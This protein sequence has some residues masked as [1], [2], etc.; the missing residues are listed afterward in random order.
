MSHTG[1]II[2]IPGL[3]IERVARTQGIEVW[4]KP[5]HRPRCKHCYRDGL[6]IKATHHRTVKHTRQGYQVMTLHLRCAEVLLLPQ[7]AL[8]SPLVCGHSSSLPRF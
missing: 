4:A 1:R 7:S 8:L 3:E 5:N 6:K 2:G